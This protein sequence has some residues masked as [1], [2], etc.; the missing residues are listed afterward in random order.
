MDIGTFW[1][2]KSKLNVIKVIQI[3]FNT[4]VVLIKNDI[5]Q[6]KDQNYA[7]EDELCIYTTEDYN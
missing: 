2:F 7:L 1:L 5:I 3:E 6:I 4:K